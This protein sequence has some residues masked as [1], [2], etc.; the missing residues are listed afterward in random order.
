MTNTDNENFNELLN[1]INNNIETRLDDRLKKAGINGYSKQSVKEYIEELEDTQRKNAENFERQ[2][3]DLTNE[4]V[5]LNKEN[6][7]LTEQLESMEKKKNEQAQLLQEEKKNNERLQRQVNELSEFR[8]R[9]NEL[10]STTEIN[11]K[12]IREQEEVIRDYEMQLQQKG[13]VQ[14]AVV[15]EAETND[16]FIDM[17]NQIDEMKATI[18]YQDK[19]ITSYK[20]TE[21]N[22]EEMHQKYEEIV[23][24]NKELYDEKS[25]LLDLLSDYQNTESKY[26]V[27]R[28][29]N[30]NN[31]NKTLKD[32]NSTINSLS[33]EITYQQKQY[34]KAEKTI[35]DVLEFLGSLQ[36]ESADLQAKNVIFYDELVKII[37]DK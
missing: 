31:I 35:S 21:Q 29:K 3:K 32:V 6:A 9:V 24:E 20:K 11:R 28:K 30:A 7:I 4:S 8:D 2:I 15:E 16:T 22:L 26:E 5:R 12:R 37:N 27:L 1:S 34:A 36:E 25:R 19:Q 18:L 17:K 13:N 10:E 33:E 23:K 14:A